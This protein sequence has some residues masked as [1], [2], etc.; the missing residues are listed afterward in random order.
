MGFFDGMAKKIDEFADK[1]AEL[2]Y[3]RVRKNDS[4]LDNL[5]E[6]EVGTLKAILRGARNHHDDWIAEKV[7]R[8]LQYRE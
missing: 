2:A 4:I 3:E 6:L 1:Q 7:K 8:E 5:D